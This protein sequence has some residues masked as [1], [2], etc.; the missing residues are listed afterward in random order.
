M[1]DEDE[2]LARKLQ[3][4]LDAEHAVA[5]QGRNVI[6]TS[7]KELAKRLQAEADLEAQFEAASEAVVAKEAA[8]KVSQS[9]AP[10]AKK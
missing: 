9:K 4:E 5:V 2:V 8:A 6:E 7:D 3:A 10:H 1:A